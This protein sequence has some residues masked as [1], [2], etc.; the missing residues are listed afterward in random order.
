VFGLYGGA[1]R[2]RAAAAEVGGI[3]AE[4]VTAAFGAVVEA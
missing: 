1:E 4:P 2:A 3:A